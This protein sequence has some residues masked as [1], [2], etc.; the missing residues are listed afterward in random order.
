MANIALGNA[1]NYT[2]GGMRFYFQE[3][4][5][6]YTP[7]AITAVTFGDDTITVD[8]DVSDDLSPGSRIVIAGG[9][10]DNAANNGTHVV[11]SVVFTTPNTIIGV[12][13]D[14]VDPSTG[15]LGTMEVVRGNELYL[16]NV[17]TGA[18]SSD[19]TFLDHFTAKTGTRMKDRSV[20]QEINITVSLELDEPNIE[21]MNLFM[22]GGSVT[23]EA[24]S[25]ASR[26]FAPYMNTERTGGAR[27]AGV[28][29]TGNE[30][31]WTIPSA[32]LKP[33][34]DFT[35]NDED[36]S[37]FS[38]E[39]EVLADSNMYPTSPYGLVDHYGVG[40]DIDVTLPLSGN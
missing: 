4:T 6:G 1:E 9:T 14:L 37:S 39:V 22:L 40:E 17:V 7:V 5:T 38:F 3:N 26:R 12:E 13:T 20:V 19:I 25:P 30:W 8:G 35:Y 36:W 24:G 34:G 27:L 2:I 29:D 15:D 28:S 31:V 10:G 21:G 11:T 16:G 32:T 33:E 18:F 23:E